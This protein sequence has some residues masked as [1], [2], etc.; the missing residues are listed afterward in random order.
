MDRSDEDHA[1]CATL[2]REA[3][4]AIIIPAPVVVE[5]DWLVASRLDAKTFDV[6]L[7]DVED[8]AVKIEALTAA[9]YARVRGL[10]TRYADLHLGFVDAAV[11]AVAERFGERKIATLDHRHFRV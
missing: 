3:E 5:L 1:A 10:C 2:L 6:F 8:G 9:D 7:S 11:I 4:E